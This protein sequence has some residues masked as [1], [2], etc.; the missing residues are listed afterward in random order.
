MPR[1]RTKKE[2]IKYGQATF[3][4]LITLFNS[5]SKK[6]QENTLLFDNR[7]PKDIL[8]HLHAWHKLF[9]TWYE[10]GM[11][12]DKPELPAPGFTWKTT[13]DLNEKLYNQYKNF[14]SDKALSLLSTSHKKILKIIDKHS[15]Q[16]LEEKKK[17]SWTGST[18]MASYL[19]S[20][21]SSHY[22]WAIDLLKKAQ[23]V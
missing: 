22:Q 10:Q 3:D 23:K 12:G 17:Y 16:E 14:S 11:A 7:T 18:N 6:Q 4:A 2:L 20:A 8:L 15:A 5:F 19:A 1:A 9:F 13:P 21:T